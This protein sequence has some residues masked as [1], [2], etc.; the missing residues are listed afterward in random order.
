MNIY[1]V[2]T[3]AYA[4]G[5]MLKEKHEGKEVK[6]VISYD[7][8]IIQESLQRLPPWLAVRQVLRFY[9]QTDCVRCLCY[10]ML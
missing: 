1:T 6:I 7:S 9:F 10:L 8:R 4:M 2:A 3:A 5:E